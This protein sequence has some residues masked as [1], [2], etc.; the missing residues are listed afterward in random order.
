MGLWRQFWDKMDERQNTKPWAAR[1]IGNIR[2]FARARNLDPAE[3]L[4]LEVKRIKD[5]IRISSE[6]GGMRSYKDA[7]AIWEVAMKLYPG[8]ITEED[9]PTL[10]RL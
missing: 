1:E 2:R 9:K 10:V 6:E 7:L 5:E 4:Q 3:T 8:H